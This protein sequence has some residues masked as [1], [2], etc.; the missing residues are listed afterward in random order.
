M[1]KQHPKSITGEEHQNNNKHMYVTSLLHVIHHNI[2]GKL[3]SRVHVML[4]G[5]GCIP[6]VVS[7][8]YAVVSLLHLHNISRTI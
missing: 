5:L 2:C 7:S 8:N 1:L 3:I 6:G 4:T